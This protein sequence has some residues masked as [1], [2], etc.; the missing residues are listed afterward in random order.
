M[1]I[2]GLRRQ[3]PRPFFLKVSA[4]AQER[5]HTGPFPALS[6]KQRPRLQAGPLF[7]ILWL[8]AQA[9]RRVTS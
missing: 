4:H 8:E 7:P 9:E 3:Y 5:S 1:A 6:P 2:A